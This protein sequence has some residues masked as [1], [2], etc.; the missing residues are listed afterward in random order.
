MPVS[1]VSSSVTPSQSSS[2]PLQ[3]S[4]VHTTPVEEEET[5]DETDED[6]EDETEEPPP[7]PWP[8]SSMRRLVRPQARAA[9]GARRRGSRKGEVRIGSGGEARRSSRDGQGTDE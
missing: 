6:T 1:G 7:P 3:T 9:R 8:D 5:T 4:I 2:I